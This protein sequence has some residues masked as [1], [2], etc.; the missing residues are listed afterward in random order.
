M[1]KDVFCCFDDTSN[2][3]APDLLAKSTMIWGFVQTS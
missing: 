1:C 3:E 2:S